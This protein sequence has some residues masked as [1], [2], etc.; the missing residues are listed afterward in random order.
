VNKDLRRK[1]IC[2]LIPNSYYTFF[3]S[4]R[5]EKGGYSSNIVTQIYKTAEDGK[6]IF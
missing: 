1:E 3:V 6:Y 5:P 4:V 2:K